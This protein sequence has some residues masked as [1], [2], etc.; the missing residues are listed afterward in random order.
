[1]QLQPGDELL[2]SVNDDAPWGHK[3]RNELMRRAKGDALLFIDDDDCYAEAGLAAV[4]RAVSLQPKA[5][6]IFRMRYPGGQ[7]IWRTPDVE[8]GNVSTAMLCVPNVPGLGRWGDRYEG[9]FD[10]LQSTLQHLD[11]YPVWHEECI[12]L[13]RPD[14]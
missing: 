12:A 9:D 6:H 11:V 14:G 13:V 4:R 10:F 1:M 8:L 3:A 7:E 2:L 5:V